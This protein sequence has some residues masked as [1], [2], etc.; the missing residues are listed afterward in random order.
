MEKKISTKGE[1]AI[2]WLK[3]E[4]EKDKYE[5]DQQKKQLIESLKGFKKEDIITPVKKLTLWQKIKKV[6]LT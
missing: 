5:L 4:I 6:I 3:N 2:D 1:Q